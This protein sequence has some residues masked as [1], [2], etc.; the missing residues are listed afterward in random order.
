M[1]YITVDEALRKSDADDF[2]RKFQVEYPED[3]EGQFRI[4]KFEI[5]R[6]DQKR[7]DTLI[8]EGLARDPGHGMFT[9]LVEVVPGAGEEGRDL[10]RVWMSDT[11]AEVLEHS[12]FLNRLP[13][14]DKVRPLRILVNGLG[15]GMVAKGALSIARVNHIDIVEV[16]PDV[17]RLVCRHLPEDKVTI[18]IG[19]AYDIKWPRGTRWDMAWHD[20]WPT[21]DDNNL[22]GMA[23][24]MKRYRDKVTF[25]QGCWQRSGCLKMADAMRRMRNKTMPIEEAL[26]ILN[27]R[28]PI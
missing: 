11:R 9:R 25:W 16:N 10:R 19:D 26:E 20:I 8:R 7:V 6:L 23:R 13:V 24:L 15:L 27:G 2:W 22:P 12:P 1:K 21:I 18:H 17:A 3:Q 4:E 28:W 5:P 14:F